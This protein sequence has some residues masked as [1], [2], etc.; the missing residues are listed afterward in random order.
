MASMIRTIRRAIKRE[1]LNGI[2]TVKLS[3]LRKRAMILRHPKPR[4]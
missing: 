2:P 1:H 4:K 3:E